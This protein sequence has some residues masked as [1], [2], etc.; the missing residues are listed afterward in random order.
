VFDNAFLRKAFFREGLSEE[1]E[2]S[3]SSQGFCTITAAMIYDEVYSHTQDTYKLQAVARRLGIDIS[4]VNWHDSRADVLVTIEVYKRILFGLD[5]KAPPGVDHRIPMPP[6]VSESAPV[7]TVSSVLP[8]TTV[9]IP[10][11]KPRL[12]E[13]GPGEGS[14]LMVM[15]PEG[16]VWNRG[17]YKGTLVEDTPDPTWFDWPLKKVRELSTEQESFLIQCLEKRGL[18]R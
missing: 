11:P 16:W 15:G 10:A 7:L 2:R 8:S 4:A 9:F 18:N 17:K 12:R 14:L 6:P 1:L 5:I 13:P 3:L